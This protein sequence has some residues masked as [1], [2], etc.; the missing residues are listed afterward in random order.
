MQAPPRPLL[1]PAH[2]PR[3]TFFLDIFHPGIRR[4]PS[5]SLP[6]TQPTARPPSFTPFTRH[7]LASLLVTAHSLPST[8]ASPESSLPKF[9]P[10]PPDPAFSRYDPLLPR[11][12]SSPDSPPIVFCPLFFPPLRC[13]AEARP[14]S[15]GSALCTRIDSWFYVAAISPPP[16]PHPFSFFSSSSLFLFPFDRSRP[17]I[18]SGKLPMQGGFYTLPLPLPYFLALCRRR[19][20]RA[21]LPRFRCPASHIDRDRFR[22]PTARRT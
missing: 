12:F 10:D 20:I 13:S 4:I 7:H 1:K 18:V 6:C 16:P 15:P 5:T 19:F 3:S 14:R 21:P 2:D 11:L 9:T 22:R 17:D 8:R